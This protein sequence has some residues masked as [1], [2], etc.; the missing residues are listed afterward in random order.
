MKTAWETIV[1]F[2][3]VWFRVACYFLIPF[4][5][6]AYE[7]FKDWNGLL[8]DTAHWFDITIKFVYSLKFGLYS[9][10]AFVDQSL[11][12]ARDHAENKKEN[13]IGT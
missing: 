4:L 2:K 12:R 3:L 8:W 6:T 10:I 7:Q 5:D 9:L 13:K 11:S 1:A